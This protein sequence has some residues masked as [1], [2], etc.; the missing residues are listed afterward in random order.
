MPLPDMPWV[1]VA[2]GSLGQ[3]LPSGLGMALAMKIDGNPARVWVMMGDSEMAEGSVWEA[4]ANASFHGGRNLIAIVDMNRLGQ[5]GPTMLE[6]DGATYAARARRS[7]GDAVEIDGHDLE[8][9]DGLTGGRGNRAPDADRRTHQEGPRRV[10]P[11]GQGGLA[12]EAAPG[13]GG[14]ERRSPSSA[15]AHSIRITPPEPAPRPPPGHR[16]TP[17]GATALRVRRSRRARPSARRWPRSRATGPDVVVL[18]GEVSN[19]TYTED[20]EAVA[21]DRFFEM[22]IA[23]QC[24]VGAP[25]ACRRSARPRSRRRSGRSSRAPTTS[26]GWRR[27]VAREPAPLRLARR[28]LDR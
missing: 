22:Y 23:E 14:R 15:G 4:M 3:G 5:R 20:F 6:W 11:G 16:S 13:R 1:D 18:D 2:T 27:S 17:A 8:A 21:P 7:D 19:S 26:S 12:R 24:M 25:S 28:R 9:I 10:V